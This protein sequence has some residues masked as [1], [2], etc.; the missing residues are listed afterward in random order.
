MSALGRKRTLLRRKLPCCA[1][2]NQH[3]G[4]EP[5][6]VFWPC[7]GV[8]AMESLWKQKLLARMYGLNVN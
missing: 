1:P 2:R 8:C 7:V 3:L 4:Q 6:Y 5:I